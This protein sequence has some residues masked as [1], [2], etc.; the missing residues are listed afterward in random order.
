M[1]QA[2]A[3]NK[4]WAEIESLK[5]AKLYSLSEDTLIYRQLNVSKT[6][7]EMKVFD[8]T[9]EMYKPLTSEEILELAHIG[10]EE[11]CRNIKRKSLIR[12]LEHERNRFHIESIKN[13]YDKAG[14]HHKRALKCIQQLRNLK[15][16]SQ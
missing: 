14:R 11:Y 10:A 8:N 4:I 6:Q 1:T 3:L 5:H 13:N 16:N 12:K 7:K 2:E 15:F 9:T